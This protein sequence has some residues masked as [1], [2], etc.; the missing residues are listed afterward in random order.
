MGFRRQKYT[1]ILRIQR[2]GGR[3]KALVLTLLQLY[4]AHTVKLSYTQ[5]KSKYGG[6]PFL[7]Q[8]LFAW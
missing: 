5:E 6:Y 4:V 7:V 2:K 3:K 8:R 1:I